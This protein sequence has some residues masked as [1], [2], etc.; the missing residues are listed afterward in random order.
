[1]LDSLAVRINES[2]PFS[3]L[4]ILNNHVFH[5]R[6]LA[7]TGCANHVHMAAA[8]ISLH[9]N[10][11]TL[12][13][14]DTFTQNNALGWDINRRRCCTRMQPLNIRGFG[15]AEGKMIQTC[16]LLGRKNKFPPMIKSAIDETLDQRSL[17]IKI[18]FLSQC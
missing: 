4:N 12:T 14:I 15:C 1:M 9:A 10:Q 8:I 17:E 11:C 18:F 5:D 2:A 16:K 3:V 13:S 6:R 7:N